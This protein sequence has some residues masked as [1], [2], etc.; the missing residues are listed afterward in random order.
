MGDSEAKV[1]TTLVVELVRASLGMV[2]SGHPP[3]Q[4]NN[5]Q[6]LT[7]TRKNNDSIDNWWKWGG[8]AV[9][10]RWSVRICLSFIFGESQI[11]Y[12]LDLRLLETQHRFKQVQPLI[13]SPKKSKSESG[14][15]KLRARV[16][17]SGRR[18]RVGNGGRP[19]AGVAG[20]GVCV[21]RTIIVYFDN[22]TW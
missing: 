11:K 18:G 9:A 14:S 19:G 7:S 17:N 4:A 6:A 22:W 20:G 10:I 15:R 2:R 12:F 21:F 1:K 13:S 16:N 3:P 8:T 5:R